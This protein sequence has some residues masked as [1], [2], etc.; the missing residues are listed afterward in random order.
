MHVVHTRVGGSIW[1]SLANAR[2]C[3]SNLV[4]YRCTNLD[5]RHL[6]DKGR[7]SIIWSNNS[8]KIG[9]RDAI[10]TRIC[11]HIVFAVEKVGTETGLK[12]CSARKEW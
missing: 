10:D 6:H 11:C 3:S 1:N 8:N 4:K 5:T 7:V 2:V 9:A 12:L